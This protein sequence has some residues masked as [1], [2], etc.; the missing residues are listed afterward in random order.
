MTTT[1][2]ASGEDWKPV[3][4]YEGQYEVSNLHRVRSVDREVRGRANKNGSQTIRKIEGKLLTPVLRGK[5]R[6]VAVNLWTGNRYKQ[7]TVRHLVF[8]AFGA[9][10]AHLPTN[11]ERKPWFLTGT[12][13][14]DTEAL[15][16][17]KGSKLVKPGVPPRSASPGR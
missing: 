2:S 9:R 5:C 7:V 17:W 16:V 13:A 3:R 14:P 1:K 8:E 6:R 10:A 11:V 12:Q 15:P 4:G